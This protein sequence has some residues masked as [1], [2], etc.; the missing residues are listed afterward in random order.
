VLTRE[1]AAGAAGTSLRASGSLL[2][3]SV[4]GR[5]VPGRSVLGR[6]VPGRSLLDPADRAEAS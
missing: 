2:G 6:S 3:R 5:S 4:P 1:F